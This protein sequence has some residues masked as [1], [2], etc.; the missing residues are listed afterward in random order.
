MRIELF[1][2]DHSTEVVALEELQKALN[3]FTRNCGWFIDTFSINKRGMIVITALSNENAA[4]PIACLLLLCKK[5]PNIFNFQIQAVRE[6][7]ALPC[8]G[9]WVRPN[10]NE[11]AIEI[12][13]NSFLRLD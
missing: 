13:K 8:I 10:H 3:Q 1:T 5:H 9:I 12:L 4:P 6:G 11:D 7:D 2:P